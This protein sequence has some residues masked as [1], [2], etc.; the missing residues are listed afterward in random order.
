MDTHRTVRAHVQLASTLRNLNRVEDA[1]QTLK[2]VKNLEMTPEQRAW[3]LAF[4][5]LR[6]LAQGLDA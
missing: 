2:D 4:E 6:N 5:L 1:I 3:V